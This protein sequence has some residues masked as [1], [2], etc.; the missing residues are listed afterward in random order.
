MKKYIFIVF[1]VANFYSLTGQT[2]KYY[3]ANENWT[4]YN[5]ASSGGIPWAIQIRY[6]Y[7]NGD[8]IINSKIYKKLFHQYK[9]SE[10]GGIYSAYQGSS[11]TAAFYVKEEN[12]SI[13]LI[14]DP[15][16][17]EFLTDTVWVYYDFLDSMIYERTYRNDLSGYQN[18]YRSIYQLEDSIKIN[19][20]T[21]RILHTS[22]GKTYEGALAAYGP[23]LSSITDPDQFDGYN[24]LECYGGND[25]T[26]LNCIWPDPIYPG[27][28]A[29]GNCNIDTLTHTLQV[30]N[31][32]DT[33]I[34][35][36]PNPCEDEIRIHAPTTVQIIVT[37]LLS[38]MGEKVNIDMT[39]NNV[40]NT[41]KLASGIYILEL[42][43]GK[44]VVYRKFCKQ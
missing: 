8:T 36:Y 33:P 25:S 20:I 23:L 19:G 3:N 10:P 26:Y 15:S 28:P 24:Y 21:R 1:I 35:L 32:S 9:Y 12:D 2:N 27:C 41:E 14:K 11:T 37:S 5:V 18:N 34:K 42:M 44:N 30:D 38:M 7:I 6:F 16:A 17:V 4:Q 22:L 31:L 40:I 39:N 43:N 13:M 29:Y